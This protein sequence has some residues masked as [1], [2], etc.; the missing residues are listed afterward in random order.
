MPSN[1]LNGVSEQLGV[2][3]AERG[4]AADPW[5]PDDVGGVVLAADAHLHYGDVDPLR[6]E[7]VDG[8]Q[9]EELEVLRAVVAQLL[10][11]A[12]EMRREQLLGRVSRCF[13]KAM[14][15]RV[16]GKVGFE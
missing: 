1:V 12:P 7:D 13:M 5:H 10:V 16:I 9:G 4:D 3:D 15:C 8:E 6:A 11:D 14:L 2:V